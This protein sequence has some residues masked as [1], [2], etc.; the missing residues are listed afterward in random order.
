MLG[1]AMHCQDR[2]GHPNEE[3]LELATDTTMPSLVTV[4]D[5]CS[6]NIAACRVKWRAPA[7]Q[8]KD[9][10]RMFVAGGLPVAVR[11]F[12]SGPWRGLHEV[13]AYSA[14]WQIG[15][16]GLEDICG[17]LGYIVPSG[18]TLVEL[19]WM[20]VKRI[21]GLDDAEVL[22]I[23]HSRLERLDVGTGYAPEVLALDEALDVLEESD[24]RAALEEQRTAPSRL[25]EHQEFKRHYF[26]RAKVVKSAGKK[27][28]A[29]NRKRPKTVQR[30][31][32]SF[33][34]SF[35]ITQPQAKKFLPPGAAIWRSVTG[36][37]GW[38][39]HFGGNA[40]ISRGFGDGVSDCRQ[41]LRDVLVRLWDQYL[42]KNG[43]EWD[44]C[45]YDF[46]LGAA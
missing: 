3:Y 36:R 27:A 18:S 11:P 8:R 7:N 9:F 38:N 44:S 14:F 17:V 35:D 10:P 6:P 28:K 16:S 30:F 20:M 22:D 19:L 13:A 12:R 34:D 1:V 32:E 23:L 29:P 26:E 43:L 25:Q 5:M 21:T 2:P 15:R 40:R 4:F 31:R 41:A 33:E 24:K 39:G 37:Q 46:D 45:P 42:T